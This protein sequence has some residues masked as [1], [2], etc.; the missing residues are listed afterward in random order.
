MKVA[1]IVERALADQA[2]QRRY[3]W[4]FAFKVS[5]HG[6]VV[7]FD[8]HF[9][10]LVAHFSGFVCQLCTDRTQFPGRTQVFTGPYPFLHR[11]QIN[12]TFQLCLR[13]DWHLDRA[14][15][16]TN[17]VFDHFNA[18]EEIRAD[19]V[20]LVHKNNAWNFVAVSLTPNCFSLR[21]NTSIR[22]QNSNSTIQN[23]Q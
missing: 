11:D 20:H 15:T 8:S 19:L 5:F 13:A 18:V 6:I 23:S 2:A 1:G 9:D 4:L 12:D 14:R 7:H 17:A 21:L 10:H 16:A 22:I 3:V